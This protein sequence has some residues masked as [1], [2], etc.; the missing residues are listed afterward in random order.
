MEL[1][2]KCGEDRQMMRLGVAHHYYLV[3][4]FPPEWVEGSAYAVVSCPSC[5]EELSASRTPLD[6]PEETLLRLVRR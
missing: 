5:G 3:D 2:P 4:G 1:C 6:P